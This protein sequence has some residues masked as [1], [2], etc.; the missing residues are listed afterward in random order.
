MLSVAKELS[1]QS[2]RH[3]EYSLQLWHKATHTGSPTSEILTFLRD[4][5]RMQLTDDHSVRLGDILELKESFQTFIGRVIEVGF[6]AT[7]ASSTWRQ[8]EF[9]QRNSECCLWMVANSCALA[10]AEEDASA[11]I[12]R[13][14][15]KSDKDMSDILNRL[16]DVSDA[17]IFKCLSFLDAS[18]QHFD[19]IRFSDVD[20][21]FS[22]LQDSLFVSC[23]I[24]GD[25]GGASANSC[26][27]Y[28]CIFDRVFFGRANIQDVII[29][30]SLLRNVIFKGS[31]GKFSLSPTTFLTDVSGPDKVPLNRTQIM[32]NQSGDIPRVIAR[33]SASIERIKKVKSFVKESLVGDI[34]RVP[35]YSRPPN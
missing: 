19:S 30:A 27:F 22:I 32:E 18:R 13:V 21:R 16:D 26:R 29:H 7:S 4:E 10:I 20:F 14:K 9:E 31:R 23:T 5:V 1:S 3:L 28:L 35:R 11:A 17:C 6:P 34:E 2:L 15:W 8:L 25:F 33:V 24:D 12:I